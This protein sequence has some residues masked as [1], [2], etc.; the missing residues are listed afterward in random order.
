MVHSNLNLKILEIVRGIR[1]CFFVQDRL[2]VLEAAACEGPFELVDVFVFTHVLHEEANLGGVEVAETLAFAVDLGVVWA[3]LSKVFR[4]ASGSLY[5][6]AEVHPYLRIIRWPPPTPWNRAI[7]LRKPFLQPL[8]LL[9]VSFIISTSNLQPQTVMRT[10]AYRHLRSAQRQRLE[11]KAMV[12]ARPPSIPF[13]VLGTSI[14]RVDFANAL[15]II[16]VV[17]LCPTGHQ[18]H[19]LQIRVFII[20]LSIALR[21]SRSNLETKRQALKRILW[22]VFRIRGTLTILIL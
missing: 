17:V 2:T 4:M 1:N 22:V 20:I 9:K 15:F 16:D 10:F 5:P 8:E 11:L 7:A 18:T 3:C 19:S 6:S 21:P 13:K 12:D 14:L